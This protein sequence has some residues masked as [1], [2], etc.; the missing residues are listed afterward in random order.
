M[1]KQAKPCA[2]SGEFLALSHLPADQQAAALDAFKKLGAERLK[3]VFEELGGTISYD[4][5]KILRLHYL[6]SL[7]T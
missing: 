4:E 2:Q 5:L 3:P 6:S 7:N 1:Q